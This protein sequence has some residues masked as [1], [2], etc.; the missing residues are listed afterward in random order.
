MGGS[1]RQIESAPNFFVAVP[2]ICYCRLEIQGL[3]HISE[4][5]IIFNSVLHSGEEA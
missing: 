1:D 5:F 4:R 3:R 2:L